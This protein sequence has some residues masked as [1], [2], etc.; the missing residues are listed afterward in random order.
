M[1]GKK[2][3]KDQQPL[4]IFYTDVWYV[5]MTEDVFMIGI[6][7]SCFCL[8]LDRGTSINIS[9]MFSICFGGRLYL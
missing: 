2:T 5:G 1:G 7:N 4:R 9:K 8:N 3:K 6:F